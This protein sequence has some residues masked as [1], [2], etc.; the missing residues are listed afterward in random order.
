MA[1]YDVY[2]TIPSLHLLLNEYKFFWNALLYS[3]TIKSLDMLVA[4][5]G[6][7]VTVFASS[8]LS[9][10]LVDMAIIPSSDSSITVTIL[11]SR[12]ALIE[13]SSTSRFQ[14]N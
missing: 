5:Q 11:A 14:Q 2:T 1:S 3:F 9:A 6:E 13:S 12:I 10:S 8:T 4:V 7:N